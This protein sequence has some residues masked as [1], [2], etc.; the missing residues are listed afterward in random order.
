M[1]DTEPED[2]A[3][4]TE[5]LIDRSKW[6]RHAM[7]NIRYNMCCL[8]FLAK[9]CGY[10]DG[11]LVGRSAP[12]AEW[13]KV[14]KAFRNTPSG[15]ATAALDEAISINDSVTISAPNKETQLIKLFADNGIKLSFTGEYSEEM[16]NL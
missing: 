15:L 4:I 3:T 8:G 14:P 5:L 16:E 12:Y 10:K 7:L 13:T 1:S 11:Q 6:G 2:E 9:A